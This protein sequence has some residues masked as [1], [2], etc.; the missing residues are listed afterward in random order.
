[1]TVKDHEADLHTAAEV[2]AVDKLVLATVN[3][4]YKRAITAASLR[5]CLAEGNP[6]A[7]LVHL[8]TFFTDVSPSL[9]VRFATSHDVSVSELA[10]AYSA[11]KTA[12]GESNPKLEAE[13]VQLAAAAE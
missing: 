11:I 12:T 1:M 9:I 8:A 7:W 4:P 13:L 5:D 10:R 3:A 6:G 2:A